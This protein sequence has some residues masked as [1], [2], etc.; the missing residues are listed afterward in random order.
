MN[1][2]KKMSFHIRGNL[3]EDR[4][5]PSNVS[6]PILKDF[7]EQVELFIKGKNRPN[8]AEIKTS[9]E[10]S[11][12]AVTVYDNDEILNSAISDYIK[13][14]E[15][16]S[17]DDIDSFRAEVIEK[18][19][20][21]AKE[22]GGLIFEMNLSVGENVISKLIINQTTEIKRKKSIWV[23][24]ELY[25]YGRVFDMGGKNNPNVHIELENGNTIKINS[26][27][28]ILAEVKENKLYKNQLL[29]IKAKQNYHTREIREERLVSFEM[30]SPHFDPEEFEEISQRS[31]EFWESVS[32][33]SKWVEEQRGNYE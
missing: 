5:S 27:A 14:K 8:L 31:T 13:V 16:N 2:L 30:Y 25:L 23:D 3:F 17:I 29:R 26:K 12:F 7:I 18:W 10:D 33:P 4:I 19:Q 15:S 22:A 21:Q 11:S 9:I 1:N 28:S 32:N 24:V 6:L 20:K